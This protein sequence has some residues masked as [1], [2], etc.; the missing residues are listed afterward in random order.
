M[1]SPAAAKVCLANDLNPF[2][3][4]QRRCTI[5]CVHQQPFALLQFTLPT[6]KKLKTL[7]M[8]KI[9]NTIIKLVYN[10]LQKLKYQLKYLAP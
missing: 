7:S 6:L 5:D 4:T 8:R 10:N 2:N 3:R 9:S 1:N